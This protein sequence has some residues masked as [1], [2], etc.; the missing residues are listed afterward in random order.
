[1]AG[2]QAF[3][4]VITQAVNDLV[5]NGF[6]NAERVA[7]WSQK[8][9]EA[10]EQVLTP[11]PVMEQLLRD[12][13]AAVYRKL[14]ERG[15]IVKLH[16]GVGR[17]TLD[18]VKP[19]LRAELDRRILAAANLIKLDRKQAIDKTLARFSGWSTSIP[20]GGTEVADKPKVKQ[21]I[22]KALAQL[23]FEERRV[24]IDQG[25]KLRASLSEILAKS[26]EAIAGIWH[27]HWRQPGYDYRE[28][29]KERDG[30]VF[31]L[32]G[33]WAIER[34]LIKVGP[35]GY[36]D[37]STTPGQEPFCRCL[38]PSTEI[39]YAV[40]I[41][42]VSRRHYDGPCLKI[43]T[44]TA[45]ERPL[46]I[47]PNHPV[48]TARGWVSAQTLDVEDDLIELVQQYVRPGMGIDDED[49][50]PPTI[51]EIFD[52]A[53]KAWGIHSERDSSLQFHGDGTPD[54]NIDIVRP[55]RLLSFSVDSPYCRQQ[56]SFT[57]ADRSP[58]K[59]G[60]LFNVFCRLLT[61][62]QNALGFS[63]KM[64]CEFAAL[65]FAQPVPAAFLRFAL[66]E[67]SNFALFCAALSM[68]ERRRR[69]F[70]PDFNADLLQS[71]TNRGIADFELLCKRHGIPTG[72]IRAAKII[73]IERDH[74][75]GHVYNLQTDKEWYSAERIISHN[76][77]YTY[78]YNLGDLP[79]DMIT[80]KGATALAE[81]RATFADSDDRPHLRLVDTT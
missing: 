26:G 9:R 73:R 4:D 65:S 66:F 75:S 58:L 14:I 54:G 62:C 46:V 55:A 23:P 31:A 27:S 18:R 28:D 15:E 22:R 13:M 20:A 74:F 25:H 1:M 34:G 8:I 45:P 39:L 5:E 59:L 63:Y 56:F 32:R 52:T 48:L 76:C 79:K 71:T 33:C 16:K 77:Y 67:H 7:F 61:T 35:A 78:V 11:G 21:N 49:H 12:T 43:V 29:H 68:A 80:K 44:A 64:A 36:L 53:A 51:A 69:G 24:L 41:S 19:E 37:G 40:G 70:R 57:K 72:Q 2:K 38:A 60:A 81:A 47:T 17:F 50:R 3:F 42:S 10:A 6:D 30:L